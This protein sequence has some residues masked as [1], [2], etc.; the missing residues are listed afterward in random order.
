MT[1]MYKRS[2]YEEILH[3]FN[4]VDKSIKD[5]QTD[6]GFDFGNMK[7]V[8]SK[9]N[10]ALNIIDEIDELKEA[11]DEGNIKEIRDAVADI[12]VFSLG[13][14]H[15][16]GENLYFG[17]KLHEWIYSDYMK[18]IN[19]DLLDD[20]LKKLEMDS[21]LV[22]ESSKKNS[23]SI[24]NLTIPNICYYCYLISDIYGFDIDE[25][26]DAIIESN[27]SKFCKDQEDL[28][29]TLQKYIDL[30]I[31]VYA[32][33]EFPKALVFSSKDQ[34]DKNGKQ[35]RADKFLK[36]IYFKEPILK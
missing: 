24:V 18:N 23:K 6:F 29:L 9:Y 22:I 17:K 35:Y 32:K 3:V 21:L 36:S 34:L 14:L 30:G 12:L 25:D 26:M 20:I 7:S 2:F 1:E 5:M 11:I 19:L 27:M 4:Y 31:E 8:E 16:S 28:N 33:G 15:H 10:F 13:L